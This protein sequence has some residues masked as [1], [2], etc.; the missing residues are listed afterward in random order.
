MGDGAQLVITGTETEER[1]AGECSF[2]AGGE[3]MITLR[4]CG[5]EVATQ[6]GLASL[7]RAW[8]GLEGKGNVGRAV[9]IAPRMAEPCKENA[10]DIVGAI[11]RVEYG[12]LFGVSAR[13]GKPL[14][15]AQGLKGACEFV[16][17]SSS[18]DNTPRRTRTVKQVPEEFGHS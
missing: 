5:G 7:S 10:D 3:E 17:L 4:H 1:E 13:D 8:T 2:A 12:E 16:A 18:F 9:L 15:F 6:P 11:V 14:D